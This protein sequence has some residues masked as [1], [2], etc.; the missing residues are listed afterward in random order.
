[1]VL[2]ALSVIAVVAVGVAM[3]DRLAAIGE[4]LLHQLGRIFRVER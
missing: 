1:M 4:A 2:I 3:E